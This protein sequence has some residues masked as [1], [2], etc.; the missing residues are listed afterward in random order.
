MTAGG[1]VCLVT[2]G[3][4]FLGRR[5]VRRLLE[6]GSAVRVVVRP[7]AKTASLEE[8]ASGFPRATLEFARVGLSS[9]RA[10][11][12]ALGGVDI[13]L[14]VAAAKTGSAAA[15]VA[16]T[17]VG[18]ENLFEAAVERRVRRLVLVSSFGVM[19][20]SS[21]PH[22]GVVDERIPLEPHPEWRDPY[23][24]A[25]LR[26]EQLAWRYHRDRGLPLV[27][28]R[29]GVVFGPGQN[30][31]SARVGLGLFG[32]FLHLGGGGT[33]PLTYVDNCADAIVRA[34]VAPGVDSQAFCIVDDD[35]PTSRQLLRRYRRQVQAV[36]AVP[37]PRPLLQ[38][39]ARL[40]VWYSRRTGGHLPAV[41]TPYKVNAMWS[42]HRF[43]NARAK[44]VLG[45]TPRLPMSAALDVAFGPSARTS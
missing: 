36:R 38:V 3:T 31:L 17:V 12:E 15:Q 8:E 37:V 19:A 4:G 13:V 28:I 40:N 1:G 7:G 41:F 27:V 32:V 21:V 29:P 30:L 14:H 18:S 9:R 34:G 20:A 26:Q 23:S 10:L 35:L 11:A 6:G 2:G 22:G 42:R 43:S 25:K 24:F 5:V 44:D 45:W 33:V 39:A 16:S